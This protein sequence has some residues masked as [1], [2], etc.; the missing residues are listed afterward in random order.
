[1]FVLRCLLI[2]IDSYHGLVQWVDLLDWVR[3]FLIGLNIILNELNGKFI[4]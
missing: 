4:I 2:D 1:M 3:F